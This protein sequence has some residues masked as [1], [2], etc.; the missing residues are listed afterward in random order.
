MCAALAHNDALYLAATVQAGFP[1]L[2]VCPKVVLKV[3]TTVYPVNAG[4]LVFDSLAQD[5]ADCIQ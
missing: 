2:L 3:S 1:G 5:R 4:S